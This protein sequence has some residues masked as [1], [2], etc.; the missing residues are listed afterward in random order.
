M[1]GEDHAVPAEP[2]PVIEEHNTPPP[3]AH[4]SSGGSTFGKYSGFSKLHV[5][6]AA[7]FQALAKHLVIIR[8][9]QFCLSCLV[10]G[11]VASRWSIQL[12]WPV[13]SAAF[14]LIFTFVMAVSGILLLKQNNEIA[15]KVFGHGGF[16]GDIV[17]SYVT[18]SGF[19]STA[20]YSRVCYTT[21]TCMNAITYV[22]NTSAYCGT[23]GAGAAFFF[24]LFFTFMYSLPFSHNVN[25]FGHMN[26]N[27]P[28][29]SDV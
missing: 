2:V 20:V 1:G 27:G 9:V 26:S 8:I 12:G 25:R 10:I 7:D 19:T 16:I 4:A 15:G 6:N 3:R 13:A 22:G 29:G 17:I 5:T 11:L 24:F 23:I 28:H 21:I 18:I 14:T